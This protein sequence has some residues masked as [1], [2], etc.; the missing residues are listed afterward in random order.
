MNKFY[1]IITITVAASTVFITMPES[2]ENASHYI[3]LLTII[4]SG[5]HMIDEFA[6][7]LPHKKTNTQLNYVR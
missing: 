5:H 6:H 1:A 7:A 4:V 3:H 2:L